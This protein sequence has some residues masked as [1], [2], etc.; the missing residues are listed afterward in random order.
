MREP[1]KDRIRLE[2]IA[3]AAANIARYTEGKT[4]NDLLTDDMMC[5]AVVYNILS[6]GEAAY[7]LTKAFQREHP[8]TPWE[9]IMKMRNILA[10]DYYKLKLQTVWE[11][12][13]HDLPPLRKQIIRYLA[14]TDWDKWENNLVVVHE[15][16]AHKSLVQAAGRM[17]LR[18]Y[19]IDEICKI[20]GLPREEI[21]SI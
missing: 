19:D 13:Q 6:V 1:I 9:D 10:H 7:H 4:Y 12:V 18:G 16:A 17:K 5:Y 8:E 20:T 11:V 2:H 3:A 21:E 14:E 15:T